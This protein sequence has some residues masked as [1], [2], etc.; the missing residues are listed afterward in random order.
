[1]Y[2]FIRIWGADVIKKATNRVLNN[3][4]LNTKFMVI[5]IVC[6]IFPLILTDGFI[7]RA[8]VNEENSNYRHVRE[9]EAEAYKSTLESTFQYDREIAR[10]I[11][12]NTVFNS[13]LNK[14]YASPYD[15]YSA[16]VEYIDH[17]FFSTLL[18]AKSDKILVYADNPTI[19]NG[20]YF[21]QMTYAKE[22]KI[23]FSNDGFGQHYAAASIWAKDISL[24]II[25]QE[26]KS[27]YANILF[28]YGMQ[29]QK[30]LATAGD[31]GLDIE[32]I[33][34]AHRDNFY[35]LFAH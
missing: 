27:Y 14:R 32:M 35:D 19:L 12:Q 21:R 11:D 22:D 6:I 18:G 33:A 10:A 26:A 20:K 9:A 34:R 25:C 24:G 31:L 5:Y 13:F 15:F 2:F 29:A 7:I 17:S 4:N 16:Y 3:M 23:L 28:P 1:M 8:L 30:A